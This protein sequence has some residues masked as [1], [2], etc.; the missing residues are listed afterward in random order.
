MTTAAYS[1]DSLVDRATASSR[2]IGYLHRL[3]AL[4]EDDRLAEQKLATHMTRYSEAELLIRQIHSL[5][6]GGTGPVSVRDTIDQFGYR[7]VHS[8]SMMTSIAVIVG[9]DRGA[10]S[11]T[12]WRWIA[13]MVAVSVVTSEATGQ[14]RDVAATAPLMAHLGYL[15]L[16][17]HAPGLVAEVDALAEERGVTRADAEQT[18]TG[19]T[20]FDL[21]DRVVASWDIQPELLA[22]ARG[23]RDSPLAAH[24]A[25]A[26]AAA[27]RFGY[28][29][30]LYSGDT[31]IPDPELDAALE[32]RGGPEW[33][34]FAVSV[35]LI[36]APGS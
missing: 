2:G 13:A 28:A 32:L 8:A 15:M 29:D 16:A 21:A 36:A 22:L 12:T 14:H 10:V 34:E 20:E 17:A 6:P 25:R 23:D 4:R 18:L 7:D 30:P 9:V 31:D 26:T 35:L 19:F 27:A 33:V 3:L 5:L 24:L 11:R 1:L